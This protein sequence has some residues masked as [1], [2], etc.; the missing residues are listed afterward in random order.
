[1]SGIQWVPVDTP[2][3]SVAQSASHIRSQSQYISTNMFRY[4]SF[5]Q[6]AIV[7]MDIKMILKI[8]QLNLSLDHF[9]FV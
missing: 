6:V 8:G 9:L 2:V 4:R 3:P 1:M 7:A 5:L